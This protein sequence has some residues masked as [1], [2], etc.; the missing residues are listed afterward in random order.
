M[1]VSRATLVV[2]LFGQLRYLAQFQLS[3]FDRYVCTLRNFTS[4][5][6]FVTFISRAT[7]SVFLFGLLCLYLGQLQLSSYLDCYVC[8]SGNYSCPLVWIVTFVSRATTAVLLFGLL[9]LYLAQLKLSSYLDCYICILHNSISRNESLF[10]ISIVTFLSLAISAVF[11]LGLLRLSL[12]NLSCL[13]IWIV[14]FVSPATFAIF[15]FGSIR[16]YLS[17]LQLFSYLDCYVC[18][19]RN[20][21]CFPIWTVTF[22]SCAI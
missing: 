3:Y 16:F 1:F 6:S 7:L 18:I 11:L 14:T 10:L 5:I 2:F 13:L 19:S 8:I 12:G 21:S 9:H 15:L 4:L 17:Q 22:V 20:L